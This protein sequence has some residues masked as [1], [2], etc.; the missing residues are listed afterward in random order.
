[1]GEQKMN[2]IC[3]FNKMIN[4]TERTKCDKCSW[5]PEYFEELKQKRRAE[6]EQKLNDDDRNDG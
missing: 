5:N 4:C 3:K 2:G 6:K 1:M